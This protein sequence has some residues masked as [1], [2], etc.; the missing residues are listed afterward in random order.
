MGTV[1]QVWTQRGR[2]Q[3]MGSGTKGVAQ[4]DRSSPYGNRFRIG[5]DGDRATVVRNFRQEVESSPEWQTKLHELAGRKAMH[6]L[7]WCHDWNGVGPSPDFCHADVIA[8]KL[9]AIYNK[10]RSAPRSPSKRDRK[11]AA[12][13]AITRA[14]GKRQP[15]EYRHAIQDGKE[16]YQAK[17]GSTII[18]VA[19]QLA[20]EVA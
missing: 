9:M 13:R 3:F 18:S 10:G 1:V 11:R 12:Y 5:P 6:L 19:Y 16:V 20:P 17:L 14:Y 7:C 2:K 15:D 8:E 4:V